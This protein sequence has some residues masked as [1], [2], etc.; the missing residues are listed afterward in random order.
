MIAIYLGVPV[1]TG[2]FPYETYKAILFAP[3]YVLWKV[4]LRVQSIVTKER[5][6]VKTERRAITART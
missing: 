1:V 2:R 6:W 4:W 5:R 3:V